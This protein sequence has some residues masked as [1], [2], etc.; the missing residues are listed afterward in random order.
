[1][2]FLLPLGEF[3][4]SQRLAY[5][6]GEGGA[7]WMGGT[8]WKCRLHAS[9]TM[10]CRGRVGVGGGH[11]ASMRE[12]CCVKCR[13]GANQI[14]TCLQRQ[15]SLRYST[16]VGVTWQLCVDNPGQ[17]IV[18][19]QIVRNFSLGM[20]CY[21]SHRHIQERESAISHL[22]AKEKMPALPCQEQILLVT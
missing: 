12:R 10:A 20:I 17:G 9:R 18:Y 19:L 22:D 1:M 15:P 14:Y 13:G 21:N 11:Y 8:R 4:L 3:S 16:I 7:R 5:W 2:V 6:P